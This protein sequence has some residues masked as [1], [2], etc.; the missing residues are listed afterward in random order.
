ME[1]DARIKRWLAVAACIA[2]CVAVEWHAPFLEPQ[3]ALQLAGHLS[4]GPA[5]TETRPRLGRKSVAAT[6]PVPLQG[7]KPHTPEDTSNPPHTNLFNVAFFINAD[8]SQ[9]RRAFMEQQLDRSR[10][11]YERWPAIHGKPSLLKTHASY[12]ERGI[13]K[14]LYLNHSVTSGV[15][16]GWGTIGTYLSHLTL[17]EHIVRRWKHNDSATFLILQDDTK[18]NDDWLEQLASEMVHAPPRWMRLLLVWRALAR[19]RD[20]HGHFCAVHPPA[21]PTESGPECCGK[22]FFHGLQAWLVRA[23]SLRCIVRRLRRRRIKNIDALM[24]DCNCPQTYAIQKRLMLGQH[25]DRELG[26]ERAAVNS[27]WRLQLGSSNASLKTSAKRNLKKTQL[28]HLFSGNM[29][30]A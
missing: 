11:Q 20:C 17:F 22:R 26:S 2:F 16:G 29:T 15:I 10:V 23:R 30:T 24:V 13:E 18:L 9:K 4:D 25:M 12:F 27:V 19:R 7:Q 14:H 21:G 8:G 28:L 1:A 6:R 5:S 3:G